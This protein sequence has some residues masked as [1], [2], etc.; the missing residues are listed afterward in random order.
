MATKAK[1]LSP[2][3]KIYLWFKDKYPDCILLFRINDRYESFFEDAELC[4]SVCGLL[5]EHR[6]KS[7]DIVPVV[8]FPFWEFSKHSKKMLSAGYKVTTCEQVGGRD[9]TRIMTPENINPLKTEPMSKIPTVLLK[10]EAYQSLRTEAAR[11]VLEIF[12]E[13]HNASND[14]QFSFTYEEARDSGFSKDRFTLALDQLLGAGLIDIVGSK[15]EKSNGFPVTLYALSNRWKF[16]G[17]RRFKHRERPKRKTTPGIKRRL[18]VR[19]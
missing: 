18:V 1:K 6:D 2:A 13:K 5:V 17:H 10:S 9:V 11:E 7:G 19:N 15:R 16:Y 14:G 8:S 4:S 12:L 3:R